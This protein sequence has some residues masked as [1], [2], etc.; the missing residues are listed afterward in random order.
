[1]YS[2]AMH[3]IQINGAMEYQSIL[4]LCENMYIWF[5][6]QNLLNLIRFNT[7]IKM[8]NS[9]INKLVGTH[10]YYFYSKLEKMILFMVK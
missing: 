4:K 1:M 2:N 7:H 6:F 9:Y 5:I 3:C 10:I 8:L